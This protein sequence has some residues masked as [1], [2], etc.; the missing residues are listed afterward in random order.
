M[1]TFSSLPAP[2]LSCTKHSYF[3]L[4]SSPP[5]RAQLL[6]WDRFG[7]QGPFHRNSPL[8][9]TTAP[10]IDNMVDRLPSLLQK[11]ASFTHE[12]NAQPAWPSSLPH[13]DGS[14][15]MPHKPG[16][17]NLSAEMLVD[18]ITPHHPIPALAISSSSLPVCL[19]ICLSAS[20]IWPLEGNKKVRSLR[21]SILGVVTPA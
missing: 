19:S 13:T 5:S 8:D 11:A 6:M 4:E 12:D 1:G 17:T 18:G 14:S 10:S 15:I 9:T 16:Q 21:V 20:P 2:S 3:G 7:L